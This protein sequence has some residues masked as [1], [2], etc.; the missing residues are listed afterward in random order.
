MPKY[1]Y[2][3]AN[4]KHE[5]EIY[6]SIHDC[7][8]DCKKCELDKSLIRVP[9]LIH[10]T[11]VKQNSK[12]KKVV[13]SVVNEFIENTKQELEVEKQTMKKEYPDQ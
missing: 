9:S 1:F 7:L 3:C 8:Q 2:R 11:T 5:F 12:T 13:G 4:C 10:N 6:H